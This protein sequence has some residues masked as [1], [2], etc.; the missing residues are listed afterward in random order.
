[1][2]NQ[3][4]ERP[5]PNNGKLWASTVIFAV[6]VTA[7]VVLLHEY[8]SEVK[9]ILHPEKELS[10]LSTDTVEMS[11]A[12]SIQ[13]VLEFRKEMKESIRM[14]SVFLNMP[15]VILV[16]IL[17]NY[18]TDLSNY[19]IVSIYESNKKVYEQDVRGGAEAQK[20]LDSLYKAPPKQIQQAKEAL[21]DTL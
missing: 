9:S 16:N 18:G 14:D 4:M 20:Y 15:D 21:K 6:L 1:M 8:K 17:K 2:E 7:A 11:V 12:P 19:E 3:L 13:E 5:K 10:E